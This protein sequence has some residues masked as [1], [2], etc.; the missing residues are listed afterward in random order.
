MKKRGFTLIEL[1][2]VV[3]IIGILAAIAVPNFLNAQNR[4]KVARLISDMKALSSAQEQYRLDNGQYTFD[5]DCGVG[6]FEI[7]SYIPLTTP[8]SYIGQIPRE[9]FWNEQ[10]DFQNMD[11][12]QTGLKPVYEYTSRVSFGPNG[13]PN[14]KDDT[15]RFNFLGSQNVEYVMISL[16]PDADQN[17]FGWGVSAFQNLLNREGGEIYDPSNGLISSGNVYVLN[18]QIIGGGF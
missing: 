11:T 14:C 12:V 2:I 18:S 15:A 8:V 7:G 17:D 4:A 10:S 16:G 9:I 13:T 3:A 6:S 5:A 1:L